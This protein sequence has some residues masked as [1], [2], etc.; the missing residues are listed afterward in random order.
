MN[1]TAIND[2]A[3]GRRVAAPGGALH[4]SDH[5]GANP[6]IVMMHG[7]P[8]DSRI[9]D[10]I[11]P[12]LLPH[13]TAAFDWLGYGRSDRMDTARF[14]SADHQAELGAVHDAQGIESAVLV[15]HDASGPDAIAYT[16]SH[17]E[18]VAH[19][20]LLNTYYGSAPVLRF[21]E[22]IQLLADHRH[23]PLADA[24]LSDPD[25]RLWLLRHTRRR[26]GYDTGSLDPDGVAATSVLPSSSAEPIS[27]TPSPPYAHGHAA[28]SPPSAT[29]TPSSPA[30]RST[31]WRSRSPWHSAAATS[32]SPLPSPLAWA[33]CSPAAPSGWSMTRRTGRSRTSPR[34]WRR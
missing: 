8:D 19:L 23:A 9:Y 22:M 10:R 31:G 7:F 5:P 29:K 32:T 27:P 21:P 28:C 17:P 3:A 24:M 16:L 4:V 14:T 30:A 34:P 1:D 25:Q 20:V 2:P 6:A 11:I 15:G 33:A 13:R 18:R 12:L 26:F